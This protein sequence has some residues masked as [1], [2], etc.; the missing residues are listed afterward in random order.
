MWTRVFWA[1]VAER[2][3]KTFMQ[4]LAVMAGV[5]GSG[6]VR[7]PWTSW[8]SVAGLAA[9]ASVITSVAST[10]VGSSGSAS[11]VVREVPI[12]Q[13]PPVSEPPL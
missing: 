8:L 5:D 13:E 2:A 3:V 6:L 7:S 11:V 4:T 10:T 1:S 9:A 12:R